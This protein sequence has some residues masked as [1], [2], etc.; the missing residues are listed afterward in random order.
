MRQTVGEQQVGKVQTQQGLPCSGSDK[1]HE[2][3]WFHDSG[4]CAVL[5]A[6]GKEMANWGVQRGLTG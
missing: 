6:C 2:A 4:K 3:V 5:W 1:D